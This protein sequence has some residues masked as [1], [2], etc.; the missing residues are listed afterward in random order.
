MENNVNCL[1]CGNEWHETKIKTLASKEAEGKR[2][3]F[4]G[5]HGWKE[6]I[7]TTKKCKGIVVRK[8]LDN[9]IA[10]HQLNHVA[11]RNNDYY[12]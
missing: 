7:C 12:K 3:A 4:K 2:I 6:I 11:A 10:D 5:G 8:E 9:K 1:K